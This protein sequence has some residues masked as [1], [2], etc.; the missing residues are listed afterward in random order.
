MRKKEK[1]TVRVFPDEIVLGNLVIMR[2]SVHLCQS[3]FLHKY[4][5]FSIHAS[6]VSFIPPLVVKNYVPC[7]CHVRTFPVL[8][9][10]TIW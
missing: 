10:R 1:I 9:I 3:K 6:H 5:R 7:I 8:L 2:F 4:L